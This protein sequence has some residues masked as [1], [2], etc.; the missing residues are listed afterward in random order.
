MHSITA[1]KVDVNIFWICFSDCS[2]GSIKNED[3]KSPLCFKQHWI[4]RK[5]ITFSIAG[6]RSYLTVYINILRRLILIIKNK[7]DFFIGTHKGTYFI[8]CIS[9]SIKSW[10]LLNNIYRRI[11]GRGTVNF[12]AKSFFWLIHFYDCH[13]HKNSIYTR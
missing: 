1:I 12:S 8:V 9:Y 4:C 2:L 7:S 5:D 10:H 11:Y 13:I 6:L 3:I